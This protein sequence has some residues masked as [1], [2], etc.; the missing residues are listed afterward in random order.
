MRRIDKDFKFDKGGGGGGGS[1]D[2]EVDK[3]RIDRNYF[4]ETVSITKLR[5]L[6]WKWT[7]HLIGEHKK[8]L[9]RNKLDEMSDIFSANDIVFLAE[10]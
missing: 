5:L 9:I 4:E 1:R 3:T 6:F 8:D 10:T 7:L 2:G